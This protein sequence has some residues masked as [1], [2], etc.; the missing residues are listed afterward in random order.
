MPIYIKNQKVNIKSTVQKS[1]MATLGRI[2]WQIHASGSGAICRIFATKSL[3][4]NFDLSF[5]ILLFNL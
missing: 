3:F 1:K 2:R 4:L 5:C